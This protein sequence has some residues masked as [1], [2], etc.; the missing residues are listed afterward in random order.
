MILN[1]EYTSADKVSGN[2]PF[3]KFDGAKKPDRT[4]YGWTGNHYLRLYEKDANLDSVFSFN[5]NANTDYH[6]GPASFS[7]DGNEVFFTLSKIPEKP[8]YVNGKLATVNLGI[9]SSKKGADG[10]WTSPVPFK[11]NKVDD[12]SVGD[13]FLLQM[14]TV[15]ISCLTCPMDVGGQIFTY[16]SALLPTIGDYL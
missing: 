12:Y 9:Y 11:Y 3:L 10:K 15:F 1:V 13:P 16:A 5:L 7:K 14:E 4:V 8:V 6:V 2:R